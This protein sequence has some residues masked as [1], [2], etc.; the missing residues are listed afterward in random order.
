[1]SAAQYDPILFANAAIQKNE[2]LEIH[3]SKI[4]RT[5]QKMVTITHQYGYRILSRDLQACPQE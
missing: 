4:S 3:R 2:L 1:M 5:T